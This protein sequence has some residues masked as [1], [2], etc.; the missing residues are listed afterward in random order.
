MIQ[1]FASKLPHLR[2]AKTRVLGLA[3]AAGWSLFAVSSYSAAETERHLQEQI[4]DLQ[5]G[6]VRLLSE[7]DQLQS[8][9]T[10]VA[11]L[12]R[13]LRMAQDEAARL[14]QERVSAQPKL[15]PAQPILNANSLVVRQQPN[16]AARAGSTSSMPPTP[17]RAPARP[18]GAA[19]TKPKPGVL[20]AETG[21]SD[22][23]R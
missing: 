2:H 16:V 13:Q 18:V 22:G 17:P 20:V 12:R 21:S 6:Q 7:R 5:A 23:K 3:A 11:Q 4:V 1:S 15:S 14:T 9:A 10:E 8:A 19:L